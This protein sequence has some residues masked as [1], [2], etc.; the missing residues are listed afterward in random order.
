VTGHHSFFAAHT[1]YATKTTGGLIADL[2]L[3][4]QC[5]LSGPQGGDLQIGGLIA[6]GKI[7]AVIFLRDVLTA[8]P[9]EPDITALLR[10]CDVHNVPVATNLAT[11]A[12][13]VRHMQFT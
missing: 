3:P 11:A 2:G 10:I 1:L 7:D 5:L 13:V 12:M 6:E 8:Q 9:H 4:V